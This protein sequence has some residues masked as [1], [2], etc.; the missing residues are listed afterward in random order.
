MTAFQAVILGIIQAFTEFLP[1][2]SSGH[3]VLVQ[4]FFLFQTPPIFFD[5]LVHIG[6]LLAI[7]FYLRKELTDLVLNYKRKENQKLIALIILGTMPI[8]LVGFLIRN[9]VETIFNSLTIL[10]ISFLLTAIILLS[11]HFIKKFE[12]NLTKI[13]WKDSIFIGFSQALAILP[14]VSRSG[15]TISAALW[16]NIDRKSSFRFSFFLAIPAI[17]GALILQLFEIRDSVKID[18]VNGLIGLVVATIFGFLALKILE[19]VLIKGKLSLF[20]CYCFLL[21]VI[22]LIFLR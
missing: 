3:L 17:L 13:N 21:G 20:G 1:I 10:G 15:A 19:K 8:I 4:K 7:I 9:R 6:T 5:I 14:G 2:S 22:V 11:T 18:I 16:K 12:K